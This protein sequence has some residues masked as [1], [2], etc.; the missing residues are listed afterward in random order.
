[1]QVR[2]NV[3]NSFCSK[4]SFLFTVCLLVMQHLRVLCPFLLTIDD[5]A[6]LITKTFTLENPHDRFEFPTAR[7]VSI[8]SK[9]V[10]I[11]VNISY[12]K[13][14]EPVTTEPREHIR[15]NICAHVNETERNSVSSVPLVGYLPSSRQTGR[16]NRYAGTTTAAISIR[17]G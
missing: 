14:H 7:R 16:P 9:P 15:V 5:T 1:M 6:L 4:M 10:I 17:N 11:T 3:G 8:V 13:I 2:R 12:R